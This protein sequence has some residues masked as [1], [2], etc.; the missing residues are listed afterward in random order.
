MKYFDKSCRFSLEKLRVIIRANDK[1]VRSILLDV[2]HKMIEKAEQRRDDETQCDR[3]SG[4]MLCDVTQAS[5]RMSK[6]ERPIIKIK[7]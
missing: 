3:S 4:V 1:L 7:L 5:V 2:K 6:K